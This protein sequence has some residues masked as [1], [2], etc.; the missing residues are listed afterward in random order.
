M[1]TNTIIVGD[2]LEVLKTLPD[3]FFDVGV[4]SPPYN[5]GERHKG[6][7]VDKVIYDKA[8]DR[9]DEPE[10]QAEQKEV[11][12]EL[13]RIIQPGGSFFYNHKLRWDRGRLFHPYEW[14]SKTK[15]VLRQEIIWQRKIAGNIR[16][17]RFWQVDERIYWLYK[18][19]REEEQEPIGEE[20]EPRHAKL[21]SVWEIR[22]EARIDWI[23]DPFPLALPTRCIFAVMDERKG[24]VIDPYAGSGTTLVAAKLLGHEFLGIEISEEYTKRA[25][26]RI[27]NAEMERG[28]L[29]EELKLHQVEMTFRERK[30]R[31]LSKSRFKRQT[32]QPRLIHEKSS[33][34]YHSGE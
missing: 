27:A 9:K 6:W 34:R 24:R 25:L 19:K 29:L 7:L 23:P 18:P 12:D 30:E 4:T 22:P 26:E 32:L 33:T 21:T 8:T 1:I 13:Y 20:V 5:K 16:G 3:D 15:W 2:A 17:W 11:L 14:I 28:V 10:Y 31:G